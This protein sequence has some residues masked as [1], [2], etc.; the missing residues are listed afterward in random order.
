MAHTREDVAAIK[1]ALIVA[2]DRYVAV[3]KGNLAAVENCKRA[4]MMTTAAIPEVEALTLHD[5]PEAIAAKTGFVRGLAD[6]IAA[7]GTPTPPSNN[8]Q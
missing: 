3:L 2:L 1:T 7:A 8:G 6:K 4:V 5:T